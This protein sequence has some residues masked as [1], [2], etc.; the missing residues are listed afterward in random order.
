MKVLIEGTAYSMAAI[1]RFTMFDLL[2][3]K[4]VTGVDFDTLQQ[5]LS[6]METMS[7]PSD[8]LGSEEHLRA[9]GALIWLLRRKAGERL[10]FEEALDFPLSEMKF[11]TEDGDELPA[12]PD[13][14]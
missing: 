8:M 10:T 1:G 7:D 13:P 5:R 2:A 4:E 6:D 12:E 3:M 9:F 14:Q 11:E